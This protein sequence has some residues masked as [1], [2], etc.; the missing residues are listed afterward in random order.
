MVC[1]TIDRKIEINFYLKSRKNR[2]HARGGGGEVWD[3][4]PAAYAGQTLQ[5]YRGEECRERYIKRFRGT[6]NYRS[7]PSAFAPGLHCMSPIV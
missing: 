6:R 2:K 7:K 4:A 5:V 1:Q 3:P